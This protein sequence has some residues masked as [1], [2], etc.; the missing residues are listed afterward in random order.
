MRKDFLLT[1]ELAGELYKNCGLLPIMDYHNHLSIS[2]INKN[3]RFRNLYELWIQP[4]PYKH[5]AMRMCGIPERC[6]TGDASEEEKFAAWC[7]IFPKL[8]GNP[9]YQWSLMELEDVLEIG[10]VPGEDNWKLIWKHGEGYL[11]RNQVSPKSIMDGYRVEYCSP[12]AFI[13][14][15]LSEY[16]QDTRVV[17][18]L[19]G[20]GALYPDKRFM[21]D[22]EGRTGDRIED[23]ESY[24]RALSKRI[25]EFK[26]M[27]CRF[28]DHSLD[29][30]FRYQKDDGKNA[31]RFDRLLKEELLNRE[32]SVN[33]AAGDMSMDRDRELLASAVLLH[34]ACEYARN[35]MVLQLHMGARRH[36]S[37]RLRRLAGAAGG[38]ASAGNSPDMVS[39]TEFL[40]D[41]EQYSGA[42]L[43]RV[44]LFT[45]NPA[46]HGMLSSLAGSY[47]K[48]HVPGLVTQGPAWWWCDHG[49]GIRSVL[50]NT[51]VYGLLC[52]F[53]GMT[54]DS[55]SFLSFARH[56]YFRRILCSWMADRV[57]SQ[58]LPRSPELL[59]KLLYDM[60][61][62]NV[63]RI[64]GSSYH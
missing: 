48:D 55:R 11:D 19:R 6:I 25:K 36:T 35:G 15:D 4:D 39:L 40:D 27:G 31:E 37:T 56:D 3:K 16:G 45:L 46:D 51:A 59:E 54:T 17:P 42:G 28:A 9:L 13:N 32:T 24:F 52:N 23:L 58:D 29:C 33:L 49:Q 41:V 63:R 21:E 53:V 18:S 47:S 57:Q 12:C 8:A 10:D 43:P 26:A 20:D 1:T 14:D 44:I 61:Y 7:G 64:V 2:H 38:Y 30:E 22:L 60:C 50:D 62:G 34:L 5:R